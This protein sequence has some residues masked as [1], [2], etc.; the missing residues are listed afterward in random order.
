VR[1]VRQARSASLLAAM[2]LFAVACGGEGTGAL[3]S[4]RAVQAIER[5]VAPQIG[6]GALE[7]S[8]EAGDGLGFGDQFTCEATTDSGDT[9]LFVATVTDGGAVDVVS[10]NVLTDAVI[11]AIEIAAIDVVRVSQGLVISPNGLQC[12]EGPLVLPA[13]D[14]LSLECGVLHPT[15]GQVHSVVI[16]LTDLRDLRM[17]VE[18]SPDPA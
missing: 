12:G 6:L 8:C 18:I 1:P 4:E 13:G 5:V 2:A 17:T 10:L 3:H 16:R 11:G 15:T 14:I 7:A 9:I